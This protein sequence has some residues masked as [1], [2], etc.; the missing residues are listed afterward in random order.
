[1]LAGLLVDVAKLRVPVGVLG[2]LQRLAGALQPVAL[3]AQQP[4]D[5]VVGDLEPLRAKR[6]GELAGL[7]W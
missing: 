7:P 3:L 4:P 5:G 1:M 6:V 2:A